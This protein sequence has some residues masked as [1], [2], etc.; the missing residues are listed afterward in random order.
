MR[1]LLLLAACGVLL[2]GCGSTAMTTRLG[3]GL[4]HRIGAVTYGERRDRVEAAIGPGR[5]TQLDN[6]RG[7]WIFYPRAALYI[8][9]YKYKGE[10]RAIAL[11][12]QSSRYRTASGAGVGMTLG[13]L[14][15]RVE[16]VCNGDGAFKHGVST[17]PS[18]DPSD[19]NHPI[20]QTNQPL[21]GL[22]DRLADE[23]CHGGRNLPGRGLGG[24]GME[25]VLRE[26]RDED[27][28]AVFEQWA[29]PAA[30]HMAAFTAPNHMDRDAFEQRW[31]RLRADESV[32]NRAIV[33]D[34]EV[35]GTIGSWAAATTVRSRIGLDAPSGGRASPPA[36]SRRSSPSTPPARCMRRVAAD[37]LGSRRVLEKCGFRVV[38]ADRGFAEAR[39]AEVD[40][41]V[42]ELD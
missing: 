30:A 16:V 33:V 35:A 25:C 6:Y 18:A 22:Q 26:L 2:C 28:A 37:N 23:A 10:G 12:T 41:L 4:D 11:V 27:L 39:G 19:C 29:D 3:I 5:T 13:Q 7:R 21:H 20:D 9:Y 32:T 40:E 8:G 34:G 38:G 1:A 42:L 17:S 36:R 24:D 31:A 15:K 14:R